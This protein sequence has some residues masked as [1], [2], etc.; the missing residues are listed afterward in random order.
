MLSAIGNGVNL[1]TMSHTPMINWGLL[2]R[3]LVV[4]FR[5]LEEQGTVWIV[6]AR[7]LQV[8]V[9]VLHVLVSHPTFY[10]LVNKSMTSKTNKVKLTPW[11]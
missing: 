9:V 1:V 5:K 4:L 7:I 8:D 2:T 6:L 11:Q 3:W 10:L